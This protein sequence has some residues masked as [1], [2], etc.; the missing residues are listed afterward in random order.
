MNSLNPV[1]FRGQGLD[2]K[3]RNLTIGRIWISSKQSRTSIADGSR[4][5]DPGDKLDKYC[6][7]VMWNDEGDNE[8]VGTIMLDEEAVIALIK[9]VLKTTVTKSLTGPKERGSKSINQFAVKRVVDKVV[10]RL[11]EGSK[12]QDVQEALKDSLVLDLVKFVRGL[13]ILFPKGELE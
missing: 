10:C 7:I 11:C 12:T 5:L 8:P 3:E 4:R 13:A 9:E 2:G 1:T 6:P